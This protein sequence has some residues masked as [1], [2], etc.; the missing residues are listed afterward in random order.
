M[1]IKI[2]LYSK[3]KDWL[4]KRGIVF[5]LSFTIPIVDILKKRR[6]RVEK[7]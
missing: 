4:L 1:M 6:K 7:L 5:R 3:A 2:P